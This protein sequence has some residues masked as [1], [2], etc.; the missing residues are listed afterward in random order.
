MPFPASGELVLGE[1]ES[2]NRENGD[3]YVMPVL[4][5]KQRR[6]G[7]RRRIEQMT[8]WPRTPEIGSAFQRLKYGVIAA[9]ASSR[10]V[11]TSST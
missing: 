8:S 3:R 5:P 9:V 1:W 2:K 10:S 11:E 4:I 7:R 6:E